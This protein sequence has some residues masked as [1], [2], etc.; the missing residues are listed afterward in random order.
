V[1]EVVKMEILRFFQRGEG[2]TMTPLLNN[3]EIWVR[4]AEVRTK[5]NQAQ[6]SKLNAQSTRNYGTVR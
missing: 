3:Q 6:S 2:Y 5:N 4:Q 1:A